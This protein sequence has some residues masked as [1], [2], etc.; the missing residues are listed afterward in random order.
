VAKAK[1]NS[2]R[3]INPSGIYGLCGT[4]LQPILAPKLRDN[5]EVCG[6]TD[7]VPEAVVALSESEHPRDQT[8]PA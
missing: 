7:T 3:K 6:E 1:K 8:L 5:G 2:N 4:R